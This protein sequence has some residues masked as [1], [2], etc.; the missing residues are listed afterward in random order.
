MGGSLLSPKCQVWPDIGPTGGPWGAIVKNGGILYVGYFIQ[1]RG[2]LFGLVDD[3]TKLLT[4]GIAKLEPLLWAEDF[5]HHRYRFVLIPDW[6][7][8][9]VGEVQSCRPFCRLWI[10][11]TERGE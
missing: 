5:L 8:R 7:P 10:G 4:R 3:S 11:G 1:S 9:K 6:V 2:F